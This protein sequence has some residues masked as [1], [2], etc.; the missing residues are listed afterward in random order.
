MPASHSPSALSASLAWLSRSTHP[1]HVSLSPPDHLFSAA[2]LLLSVSVSVTTFSAHSLDCSSDVSLPLSLSLLK[3]SH[4]KR[5]ERLVQN[6]V[7]DVCQIS[8]TSNNLVSVFSLS[9]SH[10]HLMFCS[11]KATLEWITTLFVLVVFWVSLRI[12]FV[13]SWFM[14]FRWYIATKD[15]LVLS[16]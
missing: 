1:G 3:E 15:S 5:A 10:H 9:L 7:F 14:A 12:Q 16:G 4:Y 6:T 13:T 2:N 8:S 11:I